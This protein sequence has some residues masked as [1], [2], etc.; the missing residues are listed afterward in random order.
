MPYDAPI[1]QR[2]G[3]MLYTVTGTFSTGFLTPQEA[4]HLDS[5]MDDGNPVTGTVSIYSY[6]GGCVSGGPTDPAA[7]INWDLNSGGHNCIAAIWLG[8]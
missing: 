8:F 7:G 4:Y 5:K 1:Y 2:S 3:T 6:F